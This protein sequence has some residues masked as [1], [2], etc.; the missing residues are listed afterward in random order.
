MAEA[1]NIPDPSV[2]AEELDD[3]LKTLE[4]ALAAAGGAATM[5]RSALPQIVTLAQVVGE[6]EAT[7]ARVR[8]QIGAPSQATPAP[9]MQT[10]PPAPADIFRAPA[11]E[12]SEPEQRFAEAA[13]E[14]PA[15]PAE[16]DEQAAAPE[17][18]QAEA[19]GRTSNCLVLD[20]STKAGS[21][22]LRAVDGSVNE[23]SA[24]VDVALLDYDG[25]HATLK[26][27][28]DASAN[29]NTVRESLLESLRRHLADDKDAE[30]RIDFEASSAA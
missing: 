28:I 24:V 15:P 19:I 25:R 7:M 29:P 3:A 6:M 8:Q 14:S 22:D 18:V 2:L 10:P 17:E 27:W 20:V 11:Q 23:N 16:L 5:I 21:L 26:V 13:S 4:S 30:V 12:V 9:T 1:V